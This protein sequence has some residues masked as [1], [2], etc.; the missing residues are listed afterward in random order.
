MD[1]RKK[2]EKNIEVPCPNPRCSSKGSLSYKPPHENPFVRTHQYEWQGNFKARYA[3]YSN[4]S[5]SDSLG[6]V[7]ES[8]RPHCV[9]CQTHL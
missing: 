7:I 4:I 8:T 9:T 5:D 1:Y 2:V 6:Q 3:E